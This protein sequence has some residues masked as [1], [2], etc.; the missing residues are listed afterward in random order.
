F[1]VTLFEADDRV[2]G[3]TNTV[4]A[5]VGGVSH[6][7]DTGFLVHNDLTYPHLVQLFKHLA[8]PVHASDMTFSVSLTQP[9][10]EWA[11][12][13][14]GTV[15]AQRR[16]LLRPAFLGMLRDILRFNRNAAAYLARSG[17]HALLG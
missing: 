13:N 4:D 8:V 14:L 11:G 1:S 2:G 12:T 16:N 3:H 17:P 10:L 5:T 6:P 7:V 15:F 9:D